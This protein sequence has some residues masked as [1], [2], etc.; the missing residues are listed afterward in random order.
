MHR[1]VHPYS[2][3]VINVPEKILTAPSY[4]GILKRFK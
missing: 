4:V 3:D 1:N 2:E